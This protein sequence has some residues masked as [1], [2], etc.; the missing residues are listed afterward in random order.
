MSPTG[1]Q[2]VGRVG[3]ALPLGNGV[4]GPLNEGTMETVGSSQ[5]R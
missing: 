3:P 5:Q 1:R 4:K 2:A